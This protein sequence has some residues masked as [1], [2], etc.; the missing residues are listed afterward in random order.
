MTTPTK[1]E[2]VVWP[3]EIA[4]SNRRIPIRLRCRPPAIDSTNIACFPVG[5]DPIEK[6]RTE[7]PATAIAV[8]NSVRQRSAPPTNNSV[9][10]KSIFMGPS[11]INDSLLAIRGDNTNSE[12]NSNR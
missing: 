11:S 5:N 4:K 1:S 10:T 6:T 2:A 3:I 9:I 7:S 8:A 12:A